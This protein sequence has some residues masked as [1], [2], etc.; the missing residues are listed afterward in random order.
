MNNNGIVFRQLEPDNYT[1]LILDEAQSSFSEELW[2]G[3]KVKYIFFC[4]D[5]HLQTS[6]KLLTV[7]IFLK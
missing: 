6:L 5:S 4:Y 2:D 1:D 7:A 3:E